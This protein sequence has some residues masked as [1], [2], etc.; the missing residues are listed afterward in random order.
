MLDSMSKRLHIQ[1]GRCYDCRRARATH[2]PRSCHLT[3]RPHYRI[4]L[5]LLG[6]ASNSYGPLQTFSL[7]LFVSCTPQL[8]ANSS[9]RKKHSPSSLETVLTDVATETFTPVL[10]TLRETPHKH[11]NHGVRP[12]REEHFWTQ[13]RG[14]TGSSKDKTHINVVV[15][16]HVDSGYVF[17]PLHNLD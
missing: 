9:A 2:A 12:S 14:L 15:I 8:Q 4:R 13:E 6:A 1:R 11:R 17:L 16:G 7:P 3:L 10:A 5:P